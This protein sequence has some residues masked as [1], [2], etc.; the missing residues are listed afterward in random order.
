MSR[1]E[2]TSE[3]GAA[4]MAVADS[5][6]RGRAGI[7]GWCRGT[8]G[9][10][11]IE[12]AVATPVLMVLLMGAWDFGRAMQQRARMQSAANAGVMYGARST[13]RSV[14]TIGITNAVRADANDTTGTLAVSSNA[15]CACTGGAQVACTASCGTETPRYYVAVRVQSHFATMFPYPFV[16]TSYTLVGNATMRAQ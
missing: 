13:A 3:E 7:R 1:G 11:A 15:Y 12:M 4:T 14:D 8:R 16:P 6:R 5:S 10:V 9:S 2:A